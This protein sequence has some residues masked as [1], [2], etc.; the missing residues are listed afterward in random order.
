M[1][2]Q[3]MVSY[4]RKKAPGF[5][6]QEILSIINEVQRMI[7]SQ[8]TI[9]RESLDSATGMPP[10]LETKTGRLQYDCPADCL[11]TLSIFTVDSRGYMSQGY[12]SAYANYRWNGARYPETIVSQTDAYSGQLATVTFAFDPGDTTE[13][14]FHLYALKPV[15]IDSVNIQLQVPERFHLAIVDGVLARVRTEHFGAT[16][17][18]DNWENNKMPHIVQALNHGAQRNKH[19]TLTR[20]EYQWYGSANGYR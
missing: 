13:R 16:S 4:I 20:P 1:H 9:Q 10:Y 11:K 5:E 7:L 15:D 3:A 18:W 14:Y 2:T 8:V 19:R 6:P 12:P 17:E